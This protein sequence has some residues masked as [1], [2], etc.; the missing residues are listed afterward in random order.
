LFFCGKPEVALGVCLSVIFS[1]GMVF[2]VIILQCG[3]QKG[4]TVTRQNV[5]PSFMCE[6]FLKNYYT[7][8]VCLALYTG[9]T[10]PTSITRENIPL[11][12]YYEIFLQ[13]KNTLPGD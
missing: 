1:P 8:S 10:L 4:V 6:I 13:R 2:K 7:L 9:F 11:D 12:K 3:M 5:C